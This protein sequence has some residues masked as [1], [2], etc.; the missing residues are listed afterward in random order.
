MGETFRLLR[1]ALAPAWQRLLDLLF[2]PRCVGCGD[3][4]TWFCPQC[5]ASVTP[6]QPP[7]CQ[8][9][10]R[11]LNDGRLC[12][13]C[14]RTPPIIDGIRSV[15]FF[16]APLRQA[17][18]HFKYRR[19]TELAAPLSEMM[20]A[21]W[22]QLRWSIDLLIPVPLHERRQRQRGYNQATLLAHRLGWAIGCPVTEDALI[23]QRET[24]PQVS[25]AASERRRNVAGA[26]TWQAPPL[27]GE[28]ILL[29]DD[30]CT[31]G[32]TLEACARALRQAGAG[33]IW[34]LTLARPPTVYRAAESPTFASGRPSVDPPE[35]HHNPSAGRRLSA[36][37]D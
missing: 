10:G 37:S 31:T 18:H 14:R 9:C 36:R 29:V 26:F 33:S 4:G 12:S 6:I 20:V 30:V 17:I 7:L 16:E 24:A 34:A 13:Q 35:A 1:Q 5:R 19:R 2:P 23:R 25:L 27:Q 28:S 15:A 22:P 11:P 8:R 32:A 3:P 21:Y